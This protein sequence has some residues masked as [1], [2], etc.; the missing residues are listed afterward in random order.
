M[1][2]VPRVAWAHQR[3]DLGA[4]EAY[5]GRASAVLTPPKS[6]SEA[7]GAAIAAFGSTIIVGAPDYGS[8]VGQAYIF[9]RFSNGWRRTAT[10]VPP[11]EGGTDAYGTSPGFGTAVA[12]DGDTAVVGAPGTEWTDGRAYIYRYQNGSWREVATLKG[13]AQKPGDSFGSALAISGTTVVVGAKDDAADQGSAFVFAPNGRQWRQVAQLKPPTPSEAAAFGASVGISGDT[14]A[15]GAPGVADEEGR[16][17]LYSHTRAGWKVATT[18][19]SRSQYKFGLF[20]ESLAISGSTV[21]VGA[22]SLHGGGGSFIFSRV[23]TASQRALTLTDPLK[24]D[25]LAFGG[26]TALSATTDVVGAPSMANDAGK[27]LVFSLRNS[28]WALAGKLSS[29]SATIDD[30]GTEVAITSK[31]VAVGAPLSSNGAGRV[32]LYS[33]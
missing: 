2:L 33:L 23:G 7:F 14:A 12:L 6:Q 32:L 1:V 31:L 30:F 10:L 13:P 21:S 27:V 3:A 26:A 16:V 9:Q 28:G 25:A 8:G 22:P 11:N 24:N 17:F 18:L 15:V 5:E 20:G 4:V 19:Q 29:G